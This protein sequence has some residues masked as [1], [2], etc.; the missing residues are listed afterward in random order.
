MYKV[1]YAPGARERVCGPARVKRTSLNL[2]MAL[3]EKA[4][5][6]LGATTIKQTIETALWETIALVGRVR[7]IENMSSQPYDDRKVKALEESDRRWRK[8]MDELIS[9]QENIRRDNAA[10][11]RRAG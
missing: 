2:D 5:K 4:K 9:V 10:R 3:V 11:S 8:S 1:R 7:S 6:E